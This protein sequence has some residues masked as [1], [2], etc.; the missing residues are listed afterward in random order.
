MAAYSGNK[1]RSKTVSVDTSELGSTASSAIKRPL[2]ESNHP[3]MEEIKEINRGLIDNVVNIIEED[4]D[5][6]ATSEGGDGTVC[7]C[8]FSVVALGP[9]LKSQYASA[10]M[11][12]VM[13][14]LG[15]LC[16][17]LLA[18]L[19]IFPT[20]LH[21]IIDAQ[22]PIQPLRLLIPANYPNCS[23]ILLDKFLAEVRYTCKVIRPSL[24][25][26]FSTDHCA[27]EKKSM[28]QKKPVY[29]I[30]A[31]RC[32]WNIARSQRYPA[33][34]TRDNLSTWEHVHLS[35]SMVLQL[36]L[37]PS[38]PDITV[39]KLED[40]RVRKVI[41]KMVV[42]VLDGDVSPENEEIGATFSTGRSMRVETERTLTDAQSD[43]FEL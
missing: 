43:E 18:N 38:V 12:Y 30:T 33:T 39:V 34:W 13:L 42:Y 1:Q 8:S 25:L 41:D 23:P 24:S 32:K 17:I 15:I 29:V 6:A 36:V 4:V 9:N 14:L 16:W 3:L 27:P 37:T 7:K 21:F 28:K 10:Q 2:V 31:E 26:Y 35:I 40:A 22:S 5:P 11:V 19:I 20:Y